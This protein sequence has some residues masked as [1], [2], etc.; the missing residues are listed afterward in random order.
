[1]FATDG[2]AHLYGYSDHDRYGA[3]DVAMLFEEVMM[4]IQYGAVADVAFTTNPDPNTAKCADYIV[5]WGQ[6]N[7]LS[8]LSVRTR[9]QA[10]AEEI[11]G[12]SLATELSA[13]PNNAT[14]LQTEVDW[15]TAQNRQ[16]VS[17]KNRNVNGQGS[18]LDRTSDVF[19]ED[20]TRR[21]H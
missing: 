16:A 7:R 6:R 13:L 12:R 14:P 11:L 9:A 21:R 2:A 4:F 17:P 20:F 8:D 5:R 3:E 10:V 19:K 18:G 1:M 15:C